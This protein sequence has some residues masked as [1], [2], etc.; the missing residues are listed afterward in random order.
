[1]DQKKRG[2]LAAPFLKRG[3]GRYVIGKAAEVL[4]AVGALVVAAPFLV[5]L[6]SVARILGF[7]IAG[8]AF[9]PATSA[10]DYAA[11]PRKLLVVT[12]Q[13]AI[14]VVVGL[15]LV[16]ITQPFLPPL[17]GAVVLLLALSLLA[18]SFWRGAAN[19]Q[20]HAKAAAQLIAEALARQTRDERAQHVAANP[21]AEVN[22]MMTGLGS[23]IPIALKPGSPAVGRTLADINLR[24]LTG[25]TVVAIQR[26]AEE[27]VVVP[28]GNERL[29][30]GDLLAVAGTEEA[31]D[32]A[33]RLLEPGEPASAVASC[34]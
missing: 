25:A 3:L 18:V 14:V 17:P 12:V 32:A 13:L 5:G 31:L 27:A 8:L 10:L 29:L 16:A 15:P 9:P 11:A 20:G 30:A 2:C 19:F 1:M 7:E 4:T 34:A 26:G 6:L 23:S 21:L 28:A 33:R 22:R 24:G